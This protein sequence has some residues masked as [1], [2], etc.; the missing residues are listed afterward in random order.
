MA[1]PVASNLPK[2]V[3]LGGAPSSKWPAKPVKATAHAKNHLLVVP[4]DQTAVPAM[5]TV[6]RVKSAYSH[7]D[8]QTYP[9]VYSSVHHLVVVY[10]P[11][12][13]SLRA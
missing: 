13:Q 9:V 3:V 12:P 6:K 7:P 4:P 5:V 2:A 11:T 1:K 10:L 8:H